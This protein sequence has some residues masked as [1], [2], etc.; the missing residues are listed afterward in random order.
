MLF[1]I[2]I[3]NCGQYFRTKKEIGILLAIGLPKYW[4]QRIYI[5]EAFIVVASSCILGIIIGTGVAWTMAIQRQVML[6]N[7]VPLTFPFPW[8]VLFSVVG[9]S[10]LFAV[11]SSWGPIRSLIQ[12]SIVTLMRI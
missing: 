1:L 7:A 3:I 9:L 8:N 2:N 10:F 6:G 4:L 11:L 5:E 12:N